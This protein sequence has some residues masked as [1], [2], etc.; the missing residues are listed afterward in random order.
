MRILA[1]AGGSTTGWRSWS[2]SSRNVAGPTRCLRTW[3]SSRRTCARCAPP[4]SARRPRRSWLAS[5]CTHLRSVSMGVVH[6]F[7]LRSECE[8]LPSAGPV[9]VERNLYADRSGGGRALCP[10]ER[11]AGVIRGYW[12]PRAAQLATWVTAHLV[13]GE[14]EQLFGRLGGMT[15]SRSTLDRLPKELS[16]R[17]ER[18][19]A[20]FEQS[21]RLTEEVPQEAVIVAVSLDGVMVP[22]KAGQ[23]KEKRA[24]AAAA[25]KPT[26]GP[27]GYCEAA[28]AT[29]TVYDHERAPL[30]TVRM[31]RMPESK[32]A[33][34]KGMLC[35]ELAAV[36][37]ARPELEIVAVAD[38]ARDNWRYFDRELPGAAQI[39]DFYH[40]VEHLGVAL[41][42]AY[43]EGSTRHKSQ[44]KKLRYVLEY[45]AGGI[46]KVIRSLRHLRDRFPRRKALRREVKC[47]QRNRHRMRYLEFTEQG[48]PIGS[49]MVEAACKTL[50]TQRL[51]RSGMRWNTDG[52]QAILTFRSA[53][54]SQRFDRAWNLVAS[55]YRT[56]VPRS[57]TSSLSSR[58]GPP[59]ARQSRTY[60]Q[61]EVIVAWALT[62]S[63]TTPSACGAGF[64]PGRTP[65]SA[66][67]RGRPRRPLHPGVPADSA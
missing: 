57:T 56:D 6:R 26:R 40:A 59:D 67:P 7:V 25:G 53:A 23:R 14:A 44:F 27:A 13:P 10:L 5:T 4:W 16:E 36:V 45:E 20:E 60:T 17:W 41:A 31:G 65:R 28:C 19:R 46:D 30:H 52:G 18:Q 39:A 51:K 35:D 58:E 8:Y 47:F 1:Q 24:A 3:Q 12:T 15:P 48:W 55:A 2:P 66:G 64:P 21:L 62:S 34:I 61:W 38:G 11:R 9:R 29:V 43:G 63:A 54:Q 33:T 32:K 49:G 42:S 37:A 50:V 22:M